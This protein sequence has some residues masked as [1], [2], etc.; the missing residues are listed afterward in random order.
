[1][2]STLFVFF[3]NPIVQIVFLFVGFI[4]ALLWLLPSGIQWWW[5]PLAGVY[6]VMNANRPF[7][8]VILIGGLIS[9]AIW[10]ITKFFF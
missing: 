3:T 10:L 7:G 1:M 8:Q 4:M 9:F 6:S 5:Y 2:I